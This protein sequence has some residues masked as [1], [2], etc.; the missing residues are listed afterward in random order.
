[1]SRQ[2]EAF[3]PVVA[4]P[5]RRERKAEIEG[6]GVENRLSPVILNEVKN[7]FVGVRVRATDSATRC[8]ILRR[9]ILRYAQND[10]A[11]WVLSPQLGALSSRLRSRP[12]YT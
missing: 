8:S 3:A 10:R 2:Q 4:G 1:M 7:Q 5:Y 9:V 11:C 12:L 6:L